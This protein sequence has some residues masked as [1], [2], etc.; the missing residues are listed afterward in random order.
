MRTI[1]CLLF[2]FASNLAYSQGRTS[3]KI[4]FDYAYQAH[5]DANQGDK[6]Y[7]LNS[8]NNSMFRVLASKLVGAKSRL[9]A[10]LR[11][12][13][14]AQGGRDYHITTGCDHN[15]M[16]GFDPI[17]SWIDFD[18][19]GSY[20]G[21][22]LDY[23]KKLSRYRNGFYAKVGLIGEVLL[24]ESVTGELIECGS[25]YTVA[26]FDVLAP[27]RNTTQIDI[28]SGLGYEIYIKNY[29]ALY[30]EAGLVYGLRSIYE[31]SNGF[32]GQI[33]THLLTGEVLVGIRI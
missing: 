17:S 25:I 19:K 21:L 4:G 10:G 20:M 6:L 29:T 33:K 11:Y 7:S 2:F 22:S 18:N 16:G 28:S 26:S 31:Q 9:R 24:K 23:L 32:N 3:W 27:A 5:F 14:L 12:R 15:G 30:F 1:I 8:D 13:Q